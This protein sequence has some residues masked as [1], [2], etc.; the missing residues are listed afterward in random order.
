MQQQKPDL[1]FTVTIAP[2]YRVTSCSEKLEQEARGLF[3]F[4]AFTTCPACQISAQGWEFWGEN[5]H[6]QGSAP[7]PERLRHWLKIK[8]REQWHAHHDEE[9]LTYGYHFRK[10]SAIYYRAN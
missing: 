10:G 2:V 3:G 4:H 8:A 7:T 1:T 9:T 6:C 5:G